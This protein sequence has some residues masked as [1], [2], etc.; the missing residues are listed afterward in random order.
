MFGRFKKQQDNSVRQ[1]ESVNDLQTGDIIS[2]ATLIKLPR[3]LHERSLEIIHIA[4][5]EFEHDC[6]RV[7]TLKSDDNQLVYLSIENTDGEQTLCFSKSL[8]RAD[9]ES[10]FDMEAFAGIFDPAHIRLAAE[11]I[12]AHLTG[13]MREGDYQQS[14]FD[15]QGFYHDKDYFEQGKITDSITEAGKEFRVHY[16]E[17]AEDSDFGLSAEV[18]GDGETEIYLNVYSSQHAIKDM[19]PKG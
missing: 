15:V 4:T 3:A 12:P 2:L 9:V 18:Y 14:S 7:L 16:L 19:W 5:N 10:L 8:A 17:S 13:W 1:L 6:E 11:H